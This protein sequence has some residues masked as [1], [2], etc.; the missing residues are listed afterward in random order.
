M[1]ISEFYSAKYKKRVYLLG[2][3]HTIRG[4]CGR[5]KHRFSAVD[6][7]YDLITSTDKFVDVFIEAQ[8]ISKAKPIRRITQ[9]T[10]MVEVLIMLKDCLSLQKKCEYKNLRAHYSDIRGEASN[11]LHRSII[12]FSKEGLSAK[13]AFMTKLIGG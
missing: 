5:Q 1:S 10:T 8:F 2:E 3:N 6:F 11:N 9:L 12:H 7:I 13:S 4:D